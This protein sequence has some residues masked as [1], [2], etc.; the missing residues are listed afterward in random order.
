MKRRIIVALL[1]L[2]LLVS[3]FAGC[4]SGNNVTST[5]ENASSTNENTGSTKETSDDATTDGGTDT[6]NLSAIELFKDGVAGYNYGSGELKKWEEPIT[7][8]F[9]RPID[10]NATEYLEM[11]EQGEPVENDRWIQYY[12]EALNINC[13]Y[14]LTNA[15]TG[16]YKQ[17][18]L[19][20]MSSN[21]L[22]D[23]FLIYD[24]S[25]LNQLAEAGAIWDLTDIY[26][27]N[28]NQTLGEL[29]ESEGTEIY[30]TGMVDG[31]LYAIPQK[32][33]STNAYNHCWVRQD[34]LDDLGLERPETMDDVK[35][36]A[37]AFVDNYEDNIGLMFSNSFLYEYEAIFWAFGGQQNSSRDQWVLLDDG[38]L[39]FAEVQDNMK[40]G[41][42]WIH[43]MYTSG[44]M[45]SE[46]AVE[47]TWTAL[48][49][50]VATNRCGIFY[51]PHW[52]GFS[53]Q[54]YEETM[55][56]SADWVACGIPTSVEGQE[57]QIPANNVTDGWICV[58]SA[59]ENPD[60]A[61]QLLN[62]YVEKLFGEQNDF[63]N[64]FATDINSM[65][66]KASPIWS[67]SATVDLDPCADMTAAWDSGTQTMDESKLSGSGLTYWNYI[68]DGQSAYDYMFG[69]QDSCFNYVMKTYPQDILWNQYVS[70]PTQT[71]VDRGSSLVELLD[72]YYLKMVLGE[73]DI[74]TGFDEM[75]G[76]WND[77]GGKQVTEEVNEVYNSFQ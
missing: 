58:S 5:E 7:V 64:Y 21:E 75:V 51:G 8:T 17:Q 69:P 29:L 1:T 20:A 70:A 73:I 74:D 61:V 56:E 4:G 12:K 19:F 76:Q 55:D 10:L 46:W 59:C 37:Q 47:D 54:S 63:G 9:G 13:E 36:I 16:D 22:P 44:L 45:N 34:W 67:L 42:N 48:S 43:D 66:W 39:G 50:Y 57:V 24:L 23:V 3:L 32:M 30:G 6:A 53:L 38:T 41:L 2:G 31:K 33:P 62:A 26:Q 25:M 68:K 60:A 14:E 27:E 11:A 49:N 15:N 72:T 52:Y 28:V 35:N 65:M 71:Q 77:L 18:L 40:G